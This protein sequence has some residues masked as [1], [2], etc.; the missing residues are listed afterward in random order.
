[1]AIVEFSPASPH[2]TGHPLAHFASGI[3]IARYP[4]EN[5]LDFK[6]KNWGQCA[7]VLGA[8]KHLAHWNEVCLAIEL[9]RGS[10]SSWTDSTQNQL[11]SKT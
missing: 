11:E 1:M 5:G 6:T 4:G 8:R 3:Q 7:L 9:P 10:S 2:S